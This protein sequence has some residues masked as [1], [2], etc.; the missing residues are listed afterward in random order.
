MNVIDKTFV[1]GLKADCVETF[2]KEIE[3][4]R[5]N[6]SVDDWKTHIEESN[7][8]KRMR[9]FLCQD[10]YTRWGLLKPRGYAGDATLMDFAYRHT[11]IDEHVQLTG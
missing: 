1:K 4:S 3:L 2:M 9:F 5:S 7:E 11:S 6:F 10:P 8:I